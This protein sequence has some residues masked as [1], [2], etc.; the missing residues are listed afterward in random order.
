MIS[1]QA[2]TYGGAGADAAQKKLKE[3]AERAATD[4]ARQAAQEAD[5]ARRRADAVDDDRRRTEARA[6]RLRESRRRQK[7]AR[8]RDRDHAVAY[9]LGDRDDAPLAAPPAMQAV[10]LPRPV[11]PPKNERVVAGAELDRRR[12]AGGWRREAFGL[13]DAFELAA[14]ADAGQLAGPAAR[15]YRKPELLFGQ[16]ASTTS[17][18]SAG[19]RFY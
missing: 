14:G 18:R 3:E 10:R 11:G 9:A 4:I 12:R 2:L 17:P 6:A 19:P 15:P 5:A 7:D 8:G 1:T 13:R 16:R